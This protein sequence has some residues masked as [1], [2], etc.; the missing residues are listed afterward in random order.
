MLPYWE[1]QLYKR[2][3]TIYYMFYYEFRRNNE[4]THIRVYTY[5]MILQTVI[6]I[7]Y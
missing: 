5:Q 7:G 4:P 2:Y 1:I 6:I 3:N